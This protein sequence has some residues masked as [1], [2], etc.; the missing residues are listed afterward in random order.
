[1]IASAVSVLK[2]AYHGGH[3]GFQW[4]SGF[5][6]QANLRNSMTRVT[7]LMPEARSLK[8]DGVFH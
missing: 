2:N 7:G 1:M 6:L 5:W 4:A 3:R 8:P